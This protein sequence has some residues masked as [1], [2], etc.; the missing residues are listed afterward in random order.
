ML[1]RH[2]DF[3]VTL[4][5]EQHF[6]RA[7][8]LCGVSQPALSLAIRKLEE[9]LG[10][11]LIMRGKRFMGLTAE[12]QKVL[13]WGRQI[14]ADYGHLRD[15]LVGRRKGGLTGRLRLG[16]A[17]SAMPLVPQISAQFEAKNPLARIAISL[18]PVS[19]IADAI[20]R[21]DIDGA[22]SEIGS[23]PLPALDS[24][25]LGSQ[26]LKFACP[27]DHPF[28]GDASVA[29]REAVTQ[30]LCIVD[31]AVLAHLHTRQIA[32]SIT[33]ATLDAVLAHLRR[34]Q[35]CALV[36]ESFAT[37]LSTADD[38]ILSDVTGGPRLSHA[39]LMPRRDPASPM[40]SALRESVAIL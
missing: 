27:S 4:A 23:D 1:I 16:V 15:D 22:I 30:P 31:G 10:S 39:V 21:F 2:L 5:E 19:E 33:C 3:F 14:L 40:V 26:K 34:G 11:T 7:A 32:P 24:V 12:G 17:A 9:D 29:W 38:I 28:A 13:Q 18:L 36:P 20:A 35:W 8:A 37:L 6:G 25:P